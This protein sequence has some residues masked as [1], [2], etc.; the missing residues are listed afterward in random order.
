MSRVEVYGVAFDHVIID[1][2]AIEYQVRIFNANCVAQDGFDSSSYK[3]EKDFIV[4]SLDKLGSDGWRLVGQSV[5]THQN[6]NY[7]GDS[8]ESTTHRILFTF[9]R[10][11]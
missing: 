5:L 4:K 6:G 2:M 11:T 3:D 8:T 7:V 1:L 9:A 10:E